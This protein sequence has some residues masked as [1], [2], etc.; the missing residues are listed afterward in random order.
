VDQEGLA[1]GGKWCGLGDLCHPRELTY[2]QAWQKRGSASAIFL[3]AY[4]GTTGAYNLVPWSERRHKTSAGHYRNLVISKMVA[5]G[6]R[7]T[8]DSVA[9]I[10]G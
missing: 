5:N 3:R 1:S 2:R 6:C 8:D 9:S 4:A 10:A 7:D